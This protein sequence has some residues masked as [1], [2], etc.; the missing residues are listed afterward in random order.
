MLILLVIILI[1]TIIRLYVG[2][3]HPSNLM[4]GTGHSKS[5]YILPLYA[6]IANSLNKQTTILLQTA[7]DGTV[8]T[9]LIY[10]STALMFGTNSGLFAA[11]LYS[12]C[13]IFIKS[14]TAHIPDALNYVLTAS[15]IYGTV[16]TIISG[17][18]YIIPIVFT[19][20]GVCCHFRSEYIFTVPIA[21]VTF[22]VY[23]LSTI[24]YITLGTLSMFLTMLPIAL[25]FKK[26]FN[27]FI[28]TRSGLGV[29]L[30]ESI[31]KY[32]N[33]W[34]CKASDE[35]CG[36]FLQSNGY[37]YGTIEGDNFLKRK[38]FQY[39]KEDPILFIDGWIKRFF[40]SFFYLYP[41]QYSIL[42]GTLY[43]TITCTLIILS[44][45]TLC[46]LTLPLQVFFIGLWGS[47]IGP[48]TLRLDEPR[49]VDPLYVIYFILSSLFI[50]LFI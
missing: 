9:L 4:C 43:L 18:M 31:G 16:Y 28:F 32:D 30:W 3:K 36:N 50:I 35:E 19:M 11:I 38:S 37:E 48:F 12:F 33:P 17:N 20:I 26:H 49:F 14:S 40:T 46:I 39:I 29:S 6:I 47:R 42:K 45:T 23:N 27:K 2:V 22:L 15:L 41:F 24:P 25:W 5:P 10:S 21:M 34:G 1:G 7:L 8:G 44:I 13:P